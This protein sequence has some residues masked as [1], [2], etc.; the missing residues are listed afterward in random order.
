MDAATFDESF[1]RTARLPRNRKIWETECSD[2]QWTTRM[3]DVLKQTAESLDLTVADDSEITRLDMAWVDGGNHIQVAIEHEN[4]GDERPDAL[5]NELRRLLRVQAPLR[6]LMTYVATPGKIPATRQAVE[7][8]ITASEPTFE[9]LLM[10]APYN[11]D[12]V[13]DFNSYA[14][15]PRWMAE[16][17]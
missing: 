8:I 2:R 5:K 3:F 12:D 11:L 9:F 6:V 1:R 10:I 7:G 15:R 17:L 14:F 4:W 16:R 13:R